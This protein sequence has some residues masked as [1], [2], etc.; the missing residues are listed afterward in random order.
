MM[1]AMPSATMSFVDRVQ[2]MDRILHAL[3]AAKTGEGQLLLVRGEVGSG[4]TRLLHE[5]ATEAE[6][7]GFTIG[8]GT[9]FAESVVPYH[10]WKEVLEGLGLDAILEEAPPPKLLG[11]Y[12]ITSDGG[13]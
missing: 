4:K 12:L 8:F 5:G 10:P 3:K 9:A 1:S 7:Q 11:L 2:E 13:I 6:R